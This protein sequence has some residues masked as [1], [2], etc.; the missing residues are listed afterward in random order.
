MADNKTQNPEAPPLSAASPV[1]AK[2]LY[3]MNNLKYDLFLWFMSILSDVFFREIHPR[4]SWKV[5]RNGP[6]LF[7]A[8]PHA[9][10]VGNHLYTM[11]MGQ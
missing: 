10:Q 2:E 9:N 8:A 4:G 5:P 11:R 1:K 6:I 3:P 7:V